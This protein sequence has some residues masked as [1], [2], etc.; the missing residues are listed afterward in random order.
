[1][2]YVLLPSLP[3]NVQFFLTFLF[4]TS[5]LPASAWS[6]GGGL[7]TMIL[8]HVGF[9]LFLTFL[10]QTAQGGVQDYCSLPFYL[11]YNW[12]VHSHSMSS[13]TEWGSD[14]LLVP[15]QYPNHYMTLTL[16]LRREKWEDCLDLQDQRGNDKSTHWTE[17]KSPHSDFKR[18][19]YLRQ[20]PRLEDFFPEKTDEKGADC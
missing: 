1:M 2:W 15:V 8:I 19:C 11:H 5:V 3:T 6:G 12:L 16:G 14:N 13:V 18:N 9:C 20:E 7:E 10:S 4:S 17:K